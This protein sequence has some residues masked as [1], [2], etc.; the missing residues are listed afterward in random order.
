MFITNRPDLFNCYVAKSVLKSDHYAV[1]VNCTS[2][3]ENSTKKC[4]TAASR[5]QVKCYKRSGA[6]V[7][8]LTRY[9]N[10]YNRSQVAVV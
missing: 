5:K 8:R 2:S 6:D 10:D 9:F 7:A 3:A 4:A 1:Y